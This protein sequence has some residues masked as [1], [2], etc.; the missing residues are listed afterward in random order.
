MYLTDEIIDVKVEFTD[1]GLE[2]FKRFMYQRPNDYKVDENNHFLYS[3]RTTKN[4]AINYFFKFGWDAKILEPD[5]LFLEFKKR[6]ERA[7]KVYNGMTK[8][9]IALKEKKE[10]EDGNK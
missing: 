8:S 4:Q 1:R 7:A 5:Y 10:L 3:F 9:D 6:Y 2:N